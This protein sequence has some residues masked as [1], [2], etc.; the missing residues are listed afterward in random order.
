M[1]NCIRVIGAPIDLGQDRR[2]VEMGPAALRVAGLITRIAQLG[3][4]AEDAGN[5]AVAPARLED[6]GNPSVKYLRPIAASCR[7]QSDWIQQA[8]QAG[9]FPLVLGGDHSVAI[10]ATAG[11]SAFFRQRGQSIGLIWLDAHGDCNTPETTP[12]GNIHGMALACLLGE[13]PSELT[14]LNGYSP[15][16][17]P[18][19]AVLVGVHE[20][21]PGEKLL[22]RRLGLK[23]FTMR[24]LD[25][26]GL[27]AVMEEAVAMASNGTAGLV[28]SLDMD[29]V[30]ALYAP[31]VG[32][33][34]RGGA[35]YREAHLAMEILADSLNLAALQV[36]EINPVLDERNRTAELAVEL[37]LSAL[38]KKI[39]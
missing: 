32:T 38:G 36:V 20:L 25:E 31:G 6:L 35:T 17:K 5:V 21:D 11:V 33:P 9:D 14:Q 27:R 29:F 39:Y 3:L 23:V 12:S 13:G 1:P 19:N 16:V 10:G 8:L 7:M 4:S 26:R 30:D 28:A 2:G 22:L 34:V 24:D 37:I 18:E 15:M